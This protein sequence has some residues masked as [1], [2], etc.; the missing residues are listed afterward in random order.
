MDNILTIITFL[1]LLGAVILLAFNKNAVGLIRGWTLLTAVV[2]FLVS[3]PLW[4]TFDPTVAGMQFEKVYEWIPAL[5]V[6]Y[7]VGIDGISLWLVLLTT[8]LTVI[9]ILSSLGVEKNVKA[10]MFFFLMLETGMLGALISL[11]IFLFYLFWEAMLI[12]MYFLIGVW[13]GKERIYAAVKFFIFTMVGSLL[14]LVAILALYWLNIKAGGKATFDVLELYKLDLAPN[15]QF[16]MFAAFALAFAI[17]VPMF[18]VHTWLPDAHTQAPTAG[19]VILAG[20]LLKMGTYG[21]LRF[22]M[23]LFPNAVHQFTPFMMTL[24]VIG[25]IYGA[26]VAMVQ[27]DVKK[28]VAYSSV[29]HLGYVMLGIFALNAQGVAGG[30]YQSLNHGISTGALFLHRRALPSRRRHLRAPPHA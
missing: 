28:L 22:A 26:L 24:A 21:F 6:S 11:D 19:S 8:F 16:W 10:Y 23:P 29:S 25:I 27:K 18:P 17:K 5:G 13:G 7:H 15:V 12:P 9:C 1:P 3:L 4:W 30:I 14:M 20:V 2:N